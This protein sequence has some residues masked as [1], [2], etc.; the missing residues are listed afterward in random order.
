MLR[1][2]VILLSRSLFWLLVYSSKNILSK[3]EC[4]QKNTLPGKLSSKKLLGP[5]LYLFSTRIFRQKMFLPHKN[6]VLE[7]FFGQTGNNIRSTR[8]YCSMNKFVSKKDLGATK[9]LSKKIGNSFIN[10]S[11]CLV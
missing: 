9:I 7:T 1:D 3:K 11:T 10:I 4:V 8:K 2:S 5:K 6:L